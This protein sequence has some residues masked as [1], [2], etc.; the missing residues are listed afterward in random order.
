M[1]T[2]AMSE[3]GKGGHSCSQ[4]PV[5]AAIVASGNRNLRVFVPLPSSP[6]QDCLKNALLLSLLNA[7]LIP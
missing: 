4:V 1:K 7:S 5:C 3:P 6:G 2:G